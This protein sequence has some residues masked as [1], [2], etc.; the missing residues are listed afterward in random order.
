MKRSLRDFNEFEMVELLESIGEKKFRA[1]QVYQ[2]I[3]KGIVDYDEMNNSWLVRW[4]YIIE[5][6]GKKLERDDSAR[7]RAFHK[8]HLINRLETHG[9]Q[10]LESSY[11]GG[12]FVLV[13]KKT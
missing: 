5:K 13:C 3:N 8:N 7:I 1:K 2:W 10:I 6:E 11:Q 9:V 4:K 12:S